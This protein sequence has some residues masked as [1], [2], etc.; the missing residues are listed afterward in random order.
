MK[1]SINIKSGTGNYYDYDG[2]DMCIKE[3]E[4]FPLP[5][6]GETIQIME[7]NDL[8]KTNSKGIILKEYH[9]YLI[10]DIKY[11]IGAKDNYGVTVYVIPIGRNIKIK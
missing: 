4:D 2:C 6:I 11:W 5:R 3:L 1:I 8:N 7:D 9:D 10:T